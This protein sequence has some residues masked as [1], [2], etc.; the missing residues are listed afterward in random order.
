MDTLDYL[1]ISVVIMLI[2]GYIYDKLEKNRIKDLC[3]QSRYPHE[4]L[5]PFFCVFMTCLSIFLGMGLVYG[6]IL[7][8]GSI[9]ITIV[10]VIMLPR[11]LQKYK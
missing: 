1:L 7:I 2:Y 9:I 4:T 6:F 10:M 11:V 8:I 5:F 3:P